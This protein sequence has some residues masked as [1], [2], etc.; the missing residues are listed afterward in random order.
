MYYCTTRTN[1]NVSPV[2][3]LEAY[4][5]AAQQVRDYEGVVIAYGTMHAV[6]APGS[7]CPGLPELSS[8][9]RE[10]VE[11]IVLQAYTWEDKSGMDEER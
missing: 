3:F 6:A 4:V 10:D 8:S 11:D 5:A 2:E 9:V 7:L 1:P